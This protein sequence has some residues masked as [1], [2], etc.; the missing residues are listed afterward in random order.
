VTDPSQLY[1]EAIDKVRSQVDEAQLM[2]RLTGILDLLLRTSAVRSPEAYRRLARAGLVTAKDER[3]T[4]LQGAL[5]MQK[6]LREDVLLLV[7]KLEAWEDYLDVIQGFRDLLDAQKSIEKQ[8]EK[9]T[10]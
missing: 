9:I 6:L 7:D 5:E 4:H 2:G 10:K 1:G 8:I 3:A